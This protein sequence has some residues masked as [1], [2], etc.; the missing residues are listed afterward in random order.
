MYERV[1]SSGGSTK[2]EKEKQ[3]E[4]GRG[5]KIERAFPTAQKSL[6]YQPGIVPPA[7]SRAGTCAGLAHSFLRCSLA[8]GATA[9][10]NMFKGPGPRSVAPESYSNL[11]YGRPQS[12]ARVQRYEY[13]T[14]TVLCFSGIAVV[15]L[16]TDTIR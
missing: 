14:C 2:G 15:L 4:G 16:C 5:A 11:S 3:R 6:K 8:A 10:L 12:R 7:C 1:F 13:Y 9:F